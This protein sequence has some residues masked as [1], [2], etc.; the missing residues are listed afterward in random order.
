MLQKRFDPINEMFRFKGFNEVIANT[1]YKS[2]LYVVYRALRC[3]SDD[4][5]VFKLEVFANLACGFQ[6]IHKGHHQIHQDEIG[7]FFLDLGERRQPVFCF[8]Y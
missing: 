3:Q 5:T 6:P 2:I 1:A 8:A 7:D 4:R